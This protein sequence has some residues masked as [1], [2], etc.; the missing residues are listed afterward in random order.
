[1]NLAVSIV[2]SRTA[3]STACRFIEYQSSVTTPSVTLDNVV[4]VT[5][6]FTYHLCYC[7]LLKALVEIQVKLEQAIDCKT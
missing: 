2:T 7:V 6:C 1:M 5:A 4:S 3:C